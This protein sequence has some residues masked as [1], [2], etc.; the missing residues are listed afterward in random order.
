[1]RTGSLSRPDRPGS[2]PRACGAQC[3]CAAASAP[4]I[5][6]PPPGLGSFCERARGRAVVLVARGEGFGGG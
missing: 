2:R 3:A 1:M 5:S 4:V 6:V